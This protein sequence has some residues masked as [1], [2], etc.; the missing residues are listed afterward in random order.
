MKRWTIGTGLAA[1]ALLCYGSTGALRAALP[2]PQPQ[3]ASSAIT[4]HQA[5][6]NQYCVTCHNQKTK[7]AGLTLDTMNLAEVGKDARIWEEAVRKLRGGMM[8]PPGARQ[9]EKAAVKSFVSWLETSLDRAAAEHP[10]P[11]RVALHR[12]NRAEYAN[13]VERIF[14]LHV[15]AS[16]LLPVDD[17]SDGFDNIASVLKVSPSFLDQY[18]SAAR[19]VTSRAL[20]NPTAR[21]VGLVYR[22]SGADQSSYMEGQPLGTRGGMLIEHTFP[23]DGEYVFD[24]GNLATGGYVLNMDTKHRVLL[25]IDGLKVFEASLGGEVDL[26]A[27]DQSQPQAAAVEAINARFK[28]IRIGVKS[29]IRKVG[30][31]FVARSAGQSDSVLQPFV[32]GSGVDRIPRIQQLQI[33]G[34]Y[35]P[36][37]VSDTPS[38]QRVFIC[39]PPPGASS[40]EETACATKILRNIARQAY[41][42]PAT[43]EDLA[44]PLTFFKNARSTGSF[45]A[46]IESALTLIL[47]SPKFL[48]RTEDVPSNAAPGA[49]FPIN[50][51]ELA[52][53]L[54]FFL[55]SQGPD[56]EL[57]EAAT[58]GKLKTPAVLEKQMLRMLKDSKSHA[59][60]ENF[61]FQWLNLR[62]I[63]EFVPD[64][65]VFPN[66]DQSLKAAFTR[67]LDLFIESI[68]DEDRNVTDLL[69]AD[70]TFVNE[71]LALHYGIPNIRGDRFRR[72]TLTDP[73]RFGLLGKGG[74]L[75]VTSYPNRTAPVLRGAWILER[76]LGT[77]P[78]APPP[79]V[80][81]FPENV[82][83]EKAR[84]VRERMEAHR[85]NPSCKSCHVVMDPL[86][87]ALE[88]FD[89]IGAWRATDRYSGT[90]IDAAGQLVDGTHVN[91][92]SELR[93]ALAVNPE[94]FVQTLTEKL[95]MYSL[96]R[97]V[98]YHDMPLVRRI[99][100]DA[101]RDG[102]R[103]SAIVKGIVESAPFQQVQISGS[104][105]GEN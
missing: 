95:L 52:S 86:G 35:A 30:V 1:L 4:E 56:D 64:P 8:P 93:R 82:E 87:F 104:A 81:A 65:I 44:S 66:F 26:K 31:T 94:Q 54:S 58:A 85:E 55:W 79:D 28:N 62:S 67:E 70:H 39:T 18:I 42:R 23:A 74:I 77:P 48:Y 27:I 57:L 3:A 25:T 47:S 51:L 15:D 9:P 16:S 105:K 43:D 69:V 68:I 103:F 97:T 100:R 59:M 38:R 49:V 90:P 91:N 53:R 37:G 80:E 101:A 98:E 12:M 10:S 61:A 46:G 76:I 63:R 29:G 78:A 60:A 102:Y 73:N 7:T 6:I 36:A 45:D 99:V 34:P 22:A 88:N 89:A 13:A 83:G 2:V 41:R 75:M 71:R 5:L 33:A 19:A 50:D 24:I 92:P 72:V 32:P 84:T 20:G 14:G 96:G 11:G 21:P 40:T 17:L